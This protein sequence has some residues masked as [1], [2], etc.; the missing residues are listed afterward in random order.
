M[1]YQ[2]SK[3]YKIT[4]NTTDMVYVGSTFK[5]LQQRLKAHEAAYKSFK[6]GK[7]PNNVTVFKILENADYNI[8]LIENY[9][10]NSKK[11]LEL[12]EGQIIKQFI[13]N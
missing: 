4:D 11:D 1:N 12:R 5:T 9:P 7:F 6:A 10:C 2:N 13:Y 8:E 3:I